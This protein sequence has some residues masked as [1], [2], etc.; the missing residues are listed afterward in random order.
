[1]TSTTLATRSPHR[2]RAAMRAAGLDG[3]QLAKSAGV[4]R[5]FVS[6]LLNGRRRCNPTIAAAIAQEL[7]QP[8]EYL[9][10]TAMLS[11]DS[12]NEMEDEVLSTP[13]ALMVEDPYLGFDEVAALCNIKIKTLRHMRAV[14]TGPPFHKRGQ[15]LR[16]RKSKAL[17]W[18]RDTFENDAEDTED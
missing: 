16:I 11:D 14:G 13:P 3:A 6:L 9:F 7:S 2:L 18:Y 4:S 12:H 17:D 15:L 1:M 10:T 8:V 5:A